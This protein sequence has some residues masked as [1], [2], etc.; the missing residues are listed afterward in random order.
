MCEGG[1]LKE[2]GGFSHHPRVC[3]VRFPPVFK[4]WERERKRERERERELQ[5][6]GRGGGTSVCGAG[7]EDWCMKGECSV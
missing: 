4:K 1:V 6:W 2:E 7:V 3:R 5:T